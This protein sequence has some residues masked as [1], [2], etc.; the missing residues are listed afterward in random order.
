M[1]FFTNAAERLRIQSGG[2]ISFNGDTAAANALDDYEEGT[3]TT[4]VFGG[5][6]A[7]TYSYEAVRTGGKY[8][9]IGNLVYIEAVLRISSITSAG[10][11]TLNFGGLPFGFGAN[12]ASSWNPGTGIQITHYAAG[13][14]SSV[15]DYPPPFVAIGNPSATTF[16]VYSYGKNY[17][18]A[19]VIGDLSSTS[20]IYQIAGCYQV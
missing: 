3:W 13:S 4:T 17:S 19:S 10:A 8:T 5:T 20:W 16:V 7:G 11:G 9:K 2:G 12:P 18:V 6:T 15:G 14:N 1:S